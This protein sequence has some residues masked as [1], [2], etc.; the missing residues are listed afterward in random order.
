MKSD[1]FSNHS[2]ITLL[3]EGRLSSVKMGALEIMV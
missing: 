1:F 3:D 2:K